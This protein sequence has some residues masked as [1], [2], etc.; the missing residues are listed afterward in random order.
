MVRLQSNLL[1]RRS[2]QFLF[3]SVIAALLLHY[4]F[5]PM[6][7]LFLAPIIIVWR[8]A[9][10]KGRIKQPNSMVK[11]VLVSAGFYG[12][13]YSYGLNLSIES[14]VTLLVAGLALKPLEVETKRDSY[15]LIFLCYFV[16]SQHFLFDQGP[17]AFVLVLFCLFITLVA[18]VVV[19]QS[20]QS[21]SHYKVVSKIFLLSIPLTIF[22]FFV[23]PRLGPLWSLNISTQ[24]GLVGLSESMSPGEIS[25][26]GKSDELAFRV[27]FDGD[28]P[29]V[30]ERYWR[31]LVLDFYDGVTWGTKY[32]AEV[33]WRKRVNSNLTPKYKYQV[34][35]EAHEKRWLFALTDSLPDQHKIGVTEDGLLKNRYKALNP[36]QYKA[37]VSSEAGLYSRQSDRL[38]LTRLE[39]Q[40]YLQIPDGNLNPRAKALSIALSGESESTEDF[41]RLLS[42]YY[43]SNPFVYTLSPGELDGDSRVDDFLFGTQAGFCAHYAGSAVYM[44]RHAGIPAR[45]VLGYLGGEKNALG[46]YYSVYQYD[47]HAWVELWVENKGWLRVDPTG[48]VSPERVEEGIEQAVKQEFVGFK[49]QSKWLRELRSQVQALNYYWNDWMLSYKGDRQQQ[50]LDSVFGKRSSLDLFFSIAGLF[51]GLLVFLFAIVLGSNYVRKR[52][53]KDQ[54]FKLYIKRF[55]GLGLLVDQSMTFMQ[56]EKEIVTKYPSASLEAAK[57]TNYLNSTF[58]GSSSV[59]YERSELKESKELL[60]TLFNKCRKLRLG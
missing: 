4:E 46:D 44:L 40:A 27:K 17:V 48:W 53:R 16:Q 21:N 34:I 6:W 15:V 36:F 37:E 5:L 11:I 25:E 42:E 45:V 55:S 7:V 2:L 43:L 18:Q 57:L 14:A 38:H 3:V 12:V 50:I 39:Q 22:L 1:S 47:A 23:L 30:Q 52:T 41:L 20:E 60:K 8:Y 10:Y 58:F 32:R 13:F 31:A 59:V 33:N 26:L 49:S 54:F 51:L 19:N 35:T 24:S 9:I 29:P 56:I 28:V